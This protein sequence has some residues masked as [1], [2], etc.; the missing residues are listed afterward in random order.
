MERL[1]NILYSQPS[2]SVGSHLQI[3]PTVDQNDLK[4]QFHELLQSTTWFALGWQQFTQH[5]HCSRHQKQSRN[6]LKYTGWWGFSCDS[7]DKASACNAGDLGSI[8]GLGRSLGRRKW[9]PIPVFLPRES[10][11]QRSLAGYSPRGPKE[12]DMTEQLHFLYIQDDVDRLYANTMPL[13]IRG[14]EHLWILEWWPK[15]GGVV[16]EWFSLEHWGTVILEDE[17]TEHLETPQ[18]TILFLIL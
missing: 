3:P 16:H 2:I 17:L 15:G 6:Y 9:Q 12:L 11:G 1:D 13:Y 10:H 18:G 4:N 14:L 5:L 7:E 8:P